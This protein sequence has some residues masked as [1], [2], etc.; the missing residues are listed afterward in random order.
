[1]R[2]ARRPRIALIAVPETSASVLYGLYDVLHSVG[3][4]Y[5]D[6]VI[7]TPGDALLDVIIVAATKAP[8]RGV[9]GILVE[10]HAACDE[11]L[12][13]DA[14]IVCD[15]YTPIGLALRGRF[16]DEIAWLQRIHAAG[17]LVGSVC[18]GSLLL[19]EAGLLDG[20][21]CAGH[22]AYRELFRE[23]YPLV[24]FSESAILNLGSEAAGLV[25]AGSATAWQELALHLI[26]R[27]CGPEHVLQTAKVYLLASHDDGQLPF[28]A[29][30]RR[31]QKG[32]AAISLS[33]EWIGQHYRSPSP[34][35]AMA[36]RSGLVP[37]TFARRFKSATGYLPME[38]VHALRI[39]EAKQIIETGPGSLDDVGYKVGYEDPSFFRR[40]FKRST[41]LTPAAY[42]RKF[43]A[44]VAVRPSETGRP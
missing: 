28:A 10:P 27:F 31:I 9:G 14:A 42:R 8:F 38:Y 20:Q 5:P 19:A 26:A 43:A 11:V 3:A 36:E 30:T 12:E 13:V 6:M 2:E 32:D 21:Q 35:A 1:M 34:V 4:V 22:W 16:V 25:T 41:G 17:A 37:R 15:I 40:L 44:I 7:G 39:E 33:Q 24:R 23:H 29:M 18:T